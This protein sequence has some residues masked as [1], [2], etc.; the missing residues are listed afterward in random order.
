MNVCKQKCKDG[1]GKS[2]WE[3]GENILL[4]LQVCDG[5]KQKVRLAMV[6]GRGMHF[7]PITYRQAI[8]TKST[9]YI[10]T[11]IQMYT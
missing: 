2:Q 3:V 5:L 8:I 1:E 4:K 7:S 9:K 11:Y 6:G 10:H